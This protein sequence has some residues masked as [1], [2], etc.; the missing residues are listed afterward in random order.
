MSDQFVGEIRWFTYS[1]GAPDGWQA[2][3]GTLLAISEYQELFTLIG[4]IYGGDGQMTFGVPDLRG[5]V[6]LHQGTGNGL[7]TRVIGQMSGTE[8]VTLTSGQLGG[9]THV[10]E[11]STVAATS[12][13]PT[14]QVLATLPTGDALYT[15]STS[16]ATQTILP[17]VQNTGGGWPHENCAPTLAM[18]PCIATSGIFPSQG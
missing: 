13:D 1:R 15:S 2:C 11:A 12:S 4:T 7:S 5:R 17:C 14:G 18:L 6:P 16:G 10:V 9:H 8:N 3:D